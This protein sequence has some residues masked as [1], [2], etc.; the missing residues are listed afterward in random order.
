LL[1]PIFNALNALIQNYGVYLYLVFVWLSLVVISVLGIVVSCPNRI[2]GSCQPHQH[3]FTTRRN[4]VLQPAK[5]SG[6]Q[7]R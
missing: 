6:L 2:C 5:I 3:V 1:N 4:Q 7:A